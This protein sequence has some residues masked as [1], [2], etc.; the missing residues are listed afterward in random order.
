MGACD[1]LV[2]LQPVFQFQPSSTGGK[3]LLRHKV[4]TSSGKQSPHRRNW[5]CNCRKSSRIRS[6]LT[7]PE[8]TLQ[9]QGNHVSLGLQLMEMLDWIALIEWQNASLHEWWEVCP[10]LSFPWPAGS[11]LHFPFPRDTL[12]SPGVENWCDWCDLEE[13][14]GETRHASLPPP[15]PM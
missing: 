8:C 15:T 4:L 2:I 9:T 3:H 6:A 5:Q 10:V 1:S 13:A 12:P 14:Q 7:R 11:G